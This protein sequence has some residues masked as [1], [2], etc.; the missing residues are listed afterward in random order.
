MQLSTGRSRKAELAAG[1]EKVRETEVK[2]RGVCGR[3]D[4]VAT[5]DGLFPAPTSNYFDRRM[6]INCESL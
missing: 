2:R 3:R 1:E 6:M 5:C 4:V